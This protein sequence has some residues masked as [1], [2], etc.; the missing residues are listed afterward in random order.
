[1]LPPAWRAQVSEAPFRKG[2]V[3]QR[4]G[5]GAAGELR[6]VKVGMLLMQRGGARH[7]GE[8]PVGLAGCGQVLG[9]PALLAQPAE[10]SFVAV[11]PG[12]L[13]RVALAPQCQSVSGLPGGVLRELA[14]EQ[15]HT[16]TRLADWGRIA[17]VRGVVAQLAGALL[18]LAE[19]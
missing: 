10:L 19:L 15:L 2:E 5:D 12:R 8:R 14:R 4:Q 11:T 16:G 6:M 7:E 18:Q 3:L 9:L 13:C 1:E 17:R